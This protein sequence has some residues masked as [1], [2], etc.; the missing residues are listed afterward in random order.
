[1]RCFCRIQHLQSWLHFSCNNSSFFK[2]GGVFLAIFFSGFPPVQDWLKI[3]FFVFFPKSF[4]SSDVHSKKSALGFLKIHSQE[5][6][7]NLH[8]VRPGEVFATS[9]WVK[10]P[11][12]WQIRFGC[13]TLDH[14]YAGSI[15]SCVQYIRCFC[16][17]RGFFLWKCHILSEKNKCI[18]ILLYPE[19]P[20]ST[21]AKFW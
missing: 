7:Q 3:Q 2:L 15:R 19:Q 1:M 4:P 12:I 10:S 20:P 5:H 21:S 6:W 17:I 13:T 8:Q 18:C 9:N 11:Q 14:F 16:N